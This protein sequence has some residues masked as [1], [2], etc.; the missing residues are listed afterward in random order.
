[1]RCLTNR[2][3]TRF[4][5]GHSTAAEEA[6]IGEH[7]ERCQACRRLAERL[8]D[9]KGLRGL[10][11]MTSRFGVEYGWANLG[12]DDTTLSLPNIGDLDV[13][14]QRSQSLDS[15]QTAARSPTDA[16][17]HDSP[18]RDSTADGS[19]GNGPLGDGSFG[20]SSLPDG[21][22]PEA[23]L[24]RLG[25]FEILRRLGAGGFGIVYLAYDPILKR[26]LALK[27]P[28]NPVMTD[29]IL[30]RRFLREGQAAASMHHPNI[31]AV[32]EAG[33]VDGVC[34]LAS[35][36]SPGP[37]LADWLHRQT[38]R[39]SA[40]VAA[41]ILRALAGAVSHAHE[42]GILHRDIKPGNVLLDESRPSGGLPFAPSLTDFGLAKSLD[43]G[44]HTINGALLGT[45]RYMAPEQASG[46]VDQI[47]A[48]TDVYALGVVLYELLA[49]RPPI[50]GADNADT[51]RRV[52]EEEPLPLHRIVPQVPRDLAAI[53][54]KCMHK[55]PRQRYASA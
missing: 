7:L 49:G 41:K 55:E 12:A 19:L 47:G 5:G 4:L 54:R 10:H 11:K 9:D 35:V 51:L 50:N 45:P 32:L 52:V 27:L 20:N 17:I 15:W 8:S 42:S 22:L 43:D 48:A 38:S 44:A 13:S 31:V 46:L 40:T 39:V 1:M 37:T 14:P 25:R 33:E 16:K 53:C 3:M 2:V 28:R 21:S 18:A 29:A 6:Q 26:N 34:Y 36:Y 24:S 30:R 23:T